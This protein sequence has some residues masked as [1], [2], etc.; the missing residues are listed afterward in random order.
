MPTAAPLPWAVL[1]GDDRA[2]R[3]GLSA[4]D[5]HDQAAHHH[6]T[7]GPPNLSDPH[8]VGEDVGEDHDNWFP[9]QN[10]ARPTA[11]RGVA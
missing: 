3:R 10:Y 11:G 8:R 9:T 4:R 1:R 5:D 6:P 7:L 2:L